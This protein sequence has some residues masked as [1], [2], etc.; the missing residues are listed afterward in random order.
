MPTTDREILPTILNLLVKQQRLSENTSRLVES[1]VADVGKFREQ[2]ERLAI[3]ANKLDH[4]E[5]SAGDYDRRRSECLQQLADKFEQVETR[6]EQNKD[7]II[8]LEQ[9]VHAQISALR[10]ELHNGLRDHERALVEKIEQKHDEVSREASRLKERIGHMAGRY[11]A[12]ASAGV[13]M[14]L[15]FLKW[16]IDHQG[17]K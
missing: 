12:I 6:R 2:S 1:M 8:A 14:G 5:R 16:L 13:S 7:R 17:A 15:L 9:S 4:L 11:G 10:G 3:M